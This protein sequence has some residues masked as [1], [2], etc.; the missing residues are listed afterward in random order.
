MTIANH[1]VSAKDLVSDEISD[2]VFTGH[3]IKPLFLQILAGPLK[4]YL[5]A[6]KSIGGEVANQSILVEHS[7]KAQKVFLNFASRY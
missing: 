2:S 7:F 1:S 3:W 5:D 6:S 4:S